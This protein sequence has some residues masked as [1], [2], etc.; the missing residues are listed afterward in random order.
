M[1]LHTF[2]LQTGKRAELAERVGVSP[3]YLWQVAVNYQDRKP[4]TALARRINKETLGVVTL[5]SLRPDV[6]GSNAKD[7]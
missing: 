7:G 3:N 5:E 2:L 4:S 6:W 1:D